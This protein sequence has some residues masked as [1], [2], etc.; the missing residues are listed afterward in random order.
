MVPLRRYNITMYSPYFARVREL[1]DTRGAR[2]RLGI[3][4][5]PYGTRI[6]LEQCDASAACVVLDVHGAEL[7]CGFVM[8]A[9]LAGED[10]LADEHAY[11]PNAAT[12]CAVSDK[13]ER[14]EIVQTDGAARVAIPASLWDRFFAELSIVA[15]HG[16]ALSAP[17]RAT[18]H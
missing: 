5:G 14:I 12:F 17:V 18:L 10:G 11:G 4:H 6:A 13:D 15:A 9:R 16:R 2:L 8:A 3:E 1:S 7:L